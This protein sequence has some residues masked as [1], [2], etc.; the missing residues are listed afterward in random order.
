LKV[1]FYDGYCPMCNGW[2]RAII[3]F[4][5]EKRFH[6]AAL[7]SEVA[8]RMLHPLFPDY[9]KEDTII[10][11]DEDKV[12]LRSDAALRILRNLPAPISWLYAGKLVPKSIRDKMYR[13]IASRRYRW[14]KRFDSCPVPPKEWRDRFLIH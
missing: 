14:G 7:E 5:K 2:V 11:L 10:L 4:D 8:R 13:W 6:F 12:Y 9:E 3:R 1:I